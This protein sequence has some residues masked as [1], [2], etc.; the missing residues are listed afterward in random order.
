MVG[1]KTLFG[2]R[3]QLLTLP[4]FYLCAFLCIC[5]W[6]LFSPGCNNT[7]VSHGQNTALDSTDLVAMTDDMAMKIM[8]SSAVQ[9]AIASNG[10][11]KVVVEPV[12]N[13]LRA[14]VLPKG[15]ADAFTAR[16]R[17]LLSKHA[18]EQFTW[19][20]NRGAFYNLRGQELNGVD[21]GPTPEAVNPDYSLTAT[22]TSLADEN[23][24]GRNAYYVCTY[25]LT[26]LKTRGVLW[27]GSYEVKKVAVKGFLD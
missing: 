8:G 10:P 1:V 17:S 16:V 19:I 7:A 15:A 22:F 4:A 13:D 2:F 3:L 6:I 5:G 27:T 20:M 25:E 26:N 11:L 14:E 18:R 21:L 9:Q 24:Q 12:V 23:N